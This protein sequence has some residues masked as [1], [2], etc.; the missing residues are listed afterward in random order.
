MPALAESP[1]ENF[2]RSCLEVAHG[3]CALVGELVAV[4]SA[5]I[6][7][8]F[9]ATWLA[10]TQVDIYKISGIDRGQ[11]DLQ[12]VQDVGRKRRQ[13]EEVVTVK[14][15]LK[16]DQPLR[17][18]RVHGDLAA[19]VMQAFPPAT[20]AGGG[21]GDLMGTNAGKKCVWDEYS[22]TKV[23]FTDRNKLVERLGESRV[24]RRLASQD[25]LARVLVESITL[26]AERAWV[27]LAAEGSF[28]LGPVG[29]GGVARHFLPGTAKW[30]AIYGLPFAHHHYYRLLV[31][32]AWNGEAGMQWGVLS[33]QHFVVEPLRSG[34]KEQFSAKRAL[35][36]AVRGF[37]DAMVFCFGLHFVD[38]SVA[39]RARLEAGDMASFDFTASY[40]RMELE[41]A[42][43]QF[44]M[45]FRGLT[46]VQLQEAYPE[47]HFGSLPGAASLLKGL[48]ERAVPSAVAMT[49]FRDRTETML[50][51]DDP[52]AAGRGFGRDRSVLPSR[53]LSQAHH[54][55]RTAQHRKRD[56]G[57]SLPFERP[58]AQA[59][60]PALG[61]KPCR[62]HFLN[63]MQVKNKFGTVCRRCTSTPCPW[64]HPDYAVWDKKG[65]F[66]MLDDMVSGGFLQGE[67]LKAARSAV[68]ARP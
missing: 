14:G 68:S 13:D 30:S 3:A 22:G 54:I 49:A 57:P 64:E 44:F 47:F 25:V 26:E 16:S 40:C 42:I 46:Q 59:A 1:I 5:A 60:Q 51:H 7:E 53:I 39:V 29:G 23:F 20:E 10:A 18:L 58:P 66:R 12:F 37:E 28:R 35:G 8:R 15:V 38:V 33:L 34:P 63:A 62:V 32:G 19:E 61:K 11:W 24:M 27:E 6:P 43:L 50:S 45:G 21:H 31:T 65:L 2:F 41:R 67:L 52:F 55:G 48:F 4:P 9:S 56:G 17:Y 36:E